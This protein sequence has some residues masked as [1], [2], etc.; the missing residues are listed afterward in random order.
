MGEPLEAGGV[1]EFITMVFIWLIPRIP[2][3]VSVNPAQSVG[4]IVIKL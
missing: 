1:Y 4:V 2:R 3:I